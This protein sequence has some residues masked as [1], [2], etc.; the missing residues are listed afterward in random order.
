MKITKINQLESKEPK[1][2]KNI[3]FQKMILKPYKR[4]IIV[5]KDILARKRR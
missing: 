1:I 3:A 4:Q 5:T 2:P